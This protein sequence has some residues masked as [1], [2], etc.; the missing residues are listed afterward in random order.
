MKADHRDLA[1]SQV[2][3]SVDQGSIVIVGYIPC[4][5][6]NWKGWMVFSERF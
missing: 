6:P 5:G 3:N 2:G 4:F 1:G